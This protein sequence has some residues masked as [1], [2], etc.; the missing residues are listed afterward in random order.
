MRIPNDMSLASY[1]RKLIKQDK[2]YLFYQTEEWK[3]LRADVL[4]E[5]HNE[6]Q[7]CLEHGRITTESL[8]VHHVKEL[9]DYPELAL[10]KFYTDAE[11]KRQRQLI[12]LCNACHSGRHPEKLQNPDK[13]NTFVNVERW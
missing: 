10:S 3:E 2:V 11:G 4:D 13:E 1:I 8:H 7:D 12:P 9:R 5:L 6:C